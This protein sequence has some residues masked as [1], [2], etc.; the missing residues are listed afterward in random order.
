MDDLPPPD[1]IWTYRARPD[2]HSDHACG[3][4]DGDTFDLEIDCGFRLY[5]R[6]RIRLATVTTAQIYGVPHGS[7]EFADGKR[8][9]E[10]AEAWITRACG[11][12]DAAA[13]TAPDS[14]SS[15]AFEAFAG[16]DTPDDPGTWPLRLRTRRET[17]KFGR[18]LGDVYDAE[19]NSLSQAFL[20]TYGSEVESDY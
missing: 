20:D 14:V 8:H 18:W 1:D 5:R 19:G 2:D 11:D 3:V 4:V 12:A 16:G 17:G 7:A 6:A 15:T 9:K 10:L 13:E